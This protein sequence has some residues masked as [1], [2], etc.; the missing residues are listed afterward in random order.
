MNL[1]LTVIKKSGMREVFDTHKII[2]GL[3]K[4]CEKRPIS[5]EMIQNIAN[6][7]EKNLKTTWNRKWKVKNRRNGHGQTQRNR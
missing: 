6:D 4:A 1:P 3:L 2:N 5:I 7:I